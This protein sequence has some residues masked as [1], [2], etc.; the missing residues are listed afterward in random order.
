MIPFH[1]LPGTRI[2]ARSPS[3][4]RQGRIPDAVNIPLLNDEQ[5]AAVGTCYKREGQN[6]AVEL[7][8]ELAGPQFAAMVKEAKKLEPPLTIYCWR[9]GLRSKTLA[10]ILNTAGL[11]ADVFEG[12]YKRFR[13][14]ALE[15]LELIRPIHLLGGLTG[16]GKTEQL[17]LLAEKGEQVLDLEHLASH[18][19]SSF[20][21]IDMPAQPSCEQFE[22]EIAIRW[23]GFDPNRPVWIEDENRTIGK[24]RIPDALFHQMQDARFFW[25]EV[26]KEKRLERLLKEYGSAK[27]EELIAATERLSR[28]LGS[29]RTRDIVG[30]L[31]RNKIKEAFEKLQDYYD[32]AYQ[33]NMQRRKIAIKV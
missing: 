19:G 33:H 5:R 3:E 15:S 6:A 18:R 21:T 10:W 9:G 12:G 2:D 30:M 14:S 23:S 8:F 7:G 11:Q 31:E 24:C 16:S 20:G 1:E 22:N 27:I 26:S 32:K 25:H 28:R 13:R 29:E 4:Y 17:H